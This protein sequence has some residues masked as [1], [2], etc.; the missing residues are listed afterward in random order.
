MPSN[1]QPRVPAA[2]AVVAPPDP[3]TE[4]L[5]A[6]LSTA[7]P[8]DEAQILANIEQRVRRLAHEVGQL[9]AEIESI[10][11]RTSN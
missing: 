11:K 8:E 3:G 9:R 10:I 5:L 1:V 7:S 2:G 4:E 6:R